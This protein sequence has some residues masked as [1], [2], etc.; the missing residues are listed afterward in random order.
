MAKQI[1]PCAKII[2]GNFA[3]AYVYYYALDETYYIRDEAVHNDNFLSMGV[4]FDA[5]FSFSPASLQGYKN[6]S[7]LPFTANDES[8]FEA[9]NAY[10]VVV[11]LD[12]KTCVFRFLSKTAHD[13]FM[14]AFKTNNSPLTC[15][16]SAENFISITSQIETSTL[17]DLYFLGFDS[18]RQEEIKSHMVKLGLCFPQDDLEALIGKVLVNSIPG[19]YARLKIILIP[20]AKFGLLHAGSPNPYVCSIV[21]ELN[22]LHELVELGILSQEEFDAKKQQ[23]CHP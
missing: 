8:V 15:Q 19:R 7:R 17:Y 16:A 2:Q 1:F 21:D 18:A 23:L 20:G 6:L 5:K 9:E 13:H 10:D 12:G 11:F 22:Q 14:S 4:W 3:G